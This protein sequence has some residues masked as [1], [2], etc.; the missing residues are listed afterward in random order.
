[1]FEPAACTPWPEPLEDLMSGV[2]DTLARSHS[3]VD[4]V[5]ELEAQLRWEDDGAPDVEVVEFA[6]ER[7]TSAVI[8]TARLFATAW[9]LSEDLELPKWSAAPIQ[10]QAE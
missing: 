4:R 5:Y 1:V 2:L 7:L 10:K 3:L 8:F 6:T 9:D